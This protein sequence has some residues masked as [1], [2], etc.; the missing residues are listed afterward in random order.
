MATTYR[1]RP[2]STAVARIRFHVIWID[3]LDKC[4]FVSASGICI[5]KPD[6]KYSD[7]AE[8]CARHFFFCTAQNEWRQDCAGGTHFDEQSGYCLFKRFV[9][10]CGGQATPRPKVTPPPPPNPPTFS[11]SLGPNSK[12][13]AVRKFFKNYVEKLR[14]L[15]H[16]RLCRV[17]A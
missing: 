10:A 5:G 1:M 9:P 6:G 14:W 8:P 16:S 2:T 15:W 17:W 4:Y 13:Y 7:P 12:E 3:L 11:K